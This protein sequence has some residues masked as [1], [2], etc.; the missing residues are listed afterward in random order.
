MLQP[1]R[2]GR[3]SAILDLLEE[4]ECSLRPCEVLDRLGYDDD[5]GLVARTLYQLWRR[6]AVERPEE[7]LYGL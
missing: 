4:A 3:S 1:A 7:G 5:Y 2:E 6:G